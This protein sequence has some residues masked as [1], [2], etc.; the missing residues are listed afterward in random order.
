MSTAKKGVDAILQALAQVDDKA[1]FNRE[2]E[3]TEVTNEDL[4]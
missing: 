3:L 1:E 4:S 2:I